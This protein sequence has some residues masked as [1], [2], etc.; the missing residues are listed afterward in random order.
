MDTALSQHIQQQIKAHGP[1]PF[2]D[3]MQA[4]LYTPKWGYYRRDRAKIGRDA[5]FITAPEISSLFGICIAEQIHEY[6]Q[7]HGPVSIIEYGPG[8]GTLAH[9][10]VSHLPPESLAH[11]Y[12]FDISP[13]LRATQEAL[14]DTLPRDI[15][16]KVT[17]IDTLP[18]SFSGIIIANEVLDAMP[19]HR[20]T[21]G[22]PLQ[23]QHVLWD[24]KQFTPI[25]MVSKNSALIDQV[26]RIQTPMAPGYRSEINLQAASWIQA[27]ANC[28]T[29]GLILLIDYG[30]NQQTYYH[31][32][33]HGGTLCCFRQHKASSDPFTLVGECDITAHVDF[34]QV[35][36]NAVAAGL[37]PIGYAEQSH[38]LLNLGIIEKA[39]AQYATHPIE[40]ASA[41]KLLMMPHEMGSLCKVLGLGKSLPRHN[42]QGFRDYNAIETLLNKEDL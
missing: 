35:V 17:S 11:Y 4:A 37:T 16:S 6:S 27:I 10:I 30:Y 42:W 41:M 14:I 15:A 2:A 39:Q 26:A 33:R 21:V 19:V 3:F 12:L 7:H 8:N 40:T 29:Q 28:L 24:G 34:T 1:M 13:S 5:D 20:F 25:D 31:P 36:A 9:T 23:E 38:F 32:E 18:A 22:E